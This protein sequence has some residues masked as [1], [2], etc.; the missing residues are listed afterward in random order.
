[1]S[2][3]SDV[4]QQVCQNRAGRENAWAA[5]RDLLEL[6]PR[7]AKSVFRFSGRE[8]GASAASGK[9]LVERQGFGR[10]TCRLNRR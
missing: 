2:V 1:M 5:I 7:L 3:A 9:E 8:A 6:S 4:G 10:F